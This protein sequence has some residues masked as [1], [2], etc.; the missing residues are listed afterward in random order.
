ME[1]GRVHSGGGIALMMLVIL[2]MMAVIAGSTILFVSRQYNQTV[3]QEQE[4]QAFHLAEAGVNF[5]VFSLNQS[6]FT[7]ESLITAG[8]LSG[9][10]PALGD[11]RY[12]LVFGDVAG[13]TPG[14]NV[15]V[16]SFGYDS[17]QQFCQ[18]LD[19]VV[20]RTGDAQQQ[21]IVDTWNHLQSCDILVTDQE[22]TEDAECG[23]N[24]CNEVTETCNE[25]LCIENAQC[26]SGN[27]NEDLGICEEPG[28]CT[29]DAECGSNSCNEESQT[30]HDNCT[31][32]AECGSGNCNEGT[33][34]CEEHEECIADTDCASSSCNEEAGVC[35]VVCTDN[36]ECP[37][38]QCN[39]GN[40]VCVP[41]DPDPS[42]APSS[43]GVPSGAPSPSP[44]PIKIGDEIGS[45]TGGSCTSSNDCGSGTCVFGPTGGTCLDLCLID[46]HCSSGGCSE[47]TNTC[48]EECTDSSSCPG[49]TACVSGACTPGSC[50]ISCDNLPDVIDPGCSGAASQT[51]CGRFVAYLNVIDANNPACS[52]QEI[53]SYVG[54]WEACSA[55]GG[56]PSGS[57]TP[58]SSGFPSPSSTGS[59][60][61]G[62]CD[63]WEVGLCTI[64]CG[65][66]TP[67]P[68]Q[69]P[70]TSPTFTPSPSPT[71]TFTPSP[72]F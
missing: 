39:S 55:C 34:L 72:S 20:H 63:S 62:F 10:V 68:T 14:Q 45:G 40:G 53:C 50:E 11:G 56:D 48:E 69:T 38:G 65:S 67:T 12:N 28:E 61:D 21:F 44:T 31:S 66:A 16:V 64:D 71:N 18:V 24:S 52:E 23:S 15:R 70:T 6:V 54:Q 7:T 22:C 41:P 49:G 37:S 35:D 59:C 51:F 26:G 30:C 17:T 8:S 32:D 43:S 33:Q 46:A 5:I 42:G 4:E 47:V 25:E 36:G 9:T 2:G 58:T 57:P 3:R 27:C 29:Q 13:A 19:V 1:L 60:G